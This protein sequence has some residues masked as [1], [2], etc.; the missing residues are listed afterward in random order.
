[1]SLSIDEVCEEFR[2]MEEIR[3]RTDLAGILGSLF[4][5]C[6][7]DEMAPLVYMVQGQLSPPFAGEPMGMAVRLLIRSLVEVK[8]G[9]SSSELL[10]EE[11]KKQEKFLDGLLAHLGDPGALAQTVLSSRGPSSLSFLDV[12]GILISL[13]EKEGEGSQ[14]DKV[15]ELA[16]LFRRLSSLS[17]RFVARFVMGKL[18]L[19]AGDA[20]IIEALAVAGGGRSLKS[21]VEKAYNICSDLG[22]VG[23]KIKSG[24]LESLSGLTPRPGFPI[25]VALCERLSSGEEIIERLG[26]CSVESKY[27]GFRCQIHIESGVVRIFSRNLDSMTDMFP[28]IVRAAKEI[29][30]N[31]SAIFEGEALGIDPETGTYQPF[32]VTITRKR[33][34]NVMEKS[35]ETPLRLLVFD[36]LYLDGISW[37]EKPF[38]ERREAVESLFG[39]HP[40]SPDEP[41]SPPAKT[42]GSSR[43]IITDNPEVV[44]S[45][46]EEVV[47]EGFEGVIAKRLG[48]IY[49][50]GSRNFNW[51]KLKKSYQGKMSDT[52]DLVIIGY[53]R[54]KGQ[55]L[56]LGIGAVLVAAWDSRTK[57][58]PSIARIGS[59]LTEEK[60]VML[61]EMLGDLVLPQQPAAVLSDVVPDFWVE[62]RLVV[63]V[64]ADELTRSPMHACGRGTGMASRDPGEGY[65]L[66]FPRM[67]SFVRADKNP[68]DATDVSEVVTLYEQQ[69]NLSRRSDRGNQPSVRK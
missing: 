61:S 26:K 25:R 19:G 56:K 60:W 48:G 50:A 11:S 66:R 5:H 14:V 33:K 43:L 63:T 24:G 51:I 32:Q 18:R 58:F 13:S 28:E 36:L 2:K 20:T 39:G 45:F 31:R 10:P 27:D 62:P 44:N 9:K 42:I 34:H 67:V 8:E 57:T 52:L 41:E 6:D 65:A 16:N 15:S 3:G 53:Y 37:M 64:R 46:F 49:T 1:M 12:F 30:G 23:K 47:E 35:L 40:V 54:G 22:F 17:A 7:E 38:S 55:R 68:E 29:F 69:R 4:S 59:G 21:V